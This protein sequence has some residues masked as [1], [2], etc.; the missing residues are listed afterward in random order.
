MMKPSPSHLLRD[1]TAKHGAALILI[2][3]CLVI[4]AVLLLAFLTRAK[5][6]LV[7]SKMYA[8]NNDVHTLMNTAVNIVM[9]QIRQATTTTATDCWTSQPGLIRTFTNAGLPDISYKLYSS[10]TMQV[11]GALNPA[12]EATALA[13]W[14]TQPAAY[15][16]LNDPV[17]GVYPIVDPTLAN[18]S[19][20]SSPQ[21]F[22][23]TAA[24]TTSTQTAPMPVKWLY[25]LQN[26]NLVAPVASG[27]GPTATIAGAGSSPIVGRIAFWTDDETCKVNINTAS[28]GGS[29]NGAT[30]TTTGT[31]TVSWDVPRFTNVTDQNL[32]IYQPVE[33]EFQNYPGHP[34]G[35]SLS[36]VFPTMFVSGPANAAFNPFYAIA[37][38]IQ[39][40]G[41]LN[42]TFDTSAAA[43]PPVVTLDAD[44]LYNSVD[45]LLFNANPVVTNNPPRGGNPVSPLTPLTQ[46]QLEQTKFF[47][48]A[49]SQAPETTIFGTPKIACWPI[50]S[51]LATAPST[52]FASAFDRLIAFCSTA[53]G[54]P[55]YFQRQN[56]EDQNYDYSSIPRNQTLYSYLQ[57]LLGTK[58]PGFGGNLAT[59]FG[60]DTNQILTEIFDYIRCTNLNDQN[61]PTADQYA[62][63][64]TTHLYGQAEV[65]PITIGS[66]RGF[67]RYL[68]INEAALWLI[69]T[70]DPYDSVTGTGHPFADGLY[71]TNNTINLTLSSVLPAT[72]TTISGSTKTTPKQIRIEAALILDPFTPMQGAA[73]MHPDVEVLVS[74]LENWTIKGTNDATPIPLQF[75]S[76]TLQTYTQD[77][78]FQ[79]GFPPDQL[80][81]MFN[82]G[83]YMGAT[84]GLSCRG[85]RARNGGRLPI[86]AVTTNNFVSGAKAAASPVQN[87]Q[88]PFVSE[89]TTVSVVETQTGTT[90]TTYTPLTFSGGPIVVTVRQRSTGT[91]IQTLTLNFP[92]TSVPAPT[93]NVALM[94]SS[95]PV[96]PWTFQAGGCGSVNGFPTTSR[97]NYSSNGTATG[98]PNA[99]KTYDVIY[100]MV[101]AQS[102]QTMDPRFIAMT[103]TLGSGS[104]TDSTGALFSPHP[105][106]TAGT[107]AIANSLIGNPSTGMGAFFGSNSGTLANLG[108]NSYSNGF[109]PVPK[110]PY[111]ATVAMAN[112]DWDTGIGIMA[113][114]G[115]LNE[116]DQGSVKYDS[117]GTAP[118]FNDGDSVTGTLIN[119]TSPNRVMPS[120]GMFGSLPTTFA[121][122]Q[123]A[124]FSG[125]N[126]QGWQT[127][128]FRRQPT[129]PSYVDSSGTTPK[130]SG[131][132]SNAPDYLMMDLF[133]MPVV[134][135]YAI[136]Q[137]LSTAGK[138]N[139]NYQ[140]VPFT[141][142]ERQTGLYALLKHESVTAVPASDANGVY[143]VVGSFNANANYR[144]PIQIGPTLS[145][146]DYRF[147]NS[148]G[149]G[150]Y[151]FR[152]PAEICDVNL[153]PN[154]PNYFLT[155][156]S[157]DT[158]IDTMM[159]AYWTSRA[160]TGD[161]C[162]ERPYTTIYPRL[163][164]RSNTFTV[165]YRVQALKKLPGST[166]TI[167]TEGSDLVQSE[168]RGSMLIERYLDAK[169]TS[170][171]DYAANPTTTPTLDSHYQFRIVSTNR[172]PP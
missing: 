115:F 61:L 3:G 114:G 51:A 71:H 137:M 122:S 9:A 18:G 160:L 53:N 128:L 72:T 125:A 129:H 47:L 79:L 62:G 102:G 36:A 19:S 133:W 155:S 148:D 153:I 11:S 14:S 172:F 161:N 143:K 90:S 113:D 169:D 159:S 162:R 170:I 149:T 107:S 22:T 41:S 27:S 126:N 38:R 23:I 120:P 84:W 16:D 55:Y 138:I 75:P 50:N 144:L 140:I 89:P 105:K 15:T 4:L 82:Y 37:P 100:S 158:A 59:K 171:P 1:R 66:T 134:E 77:G 35:V 80:G 106:Y 12:T 96:E 49:H 87:E 67:G 42:G 78:V 116:P 110:V 33:N 145:Q 70:A 26:G 111:P 24:P 117:S 13:T 10:D 69:C 119:F 30:T 21:G 48:T 108:G 98:N 74:G 123:A 91:V 6:E 135:P 76:Q 34:A 8:D 93:L 52:P 146:F 164:T 94:A 68:T 103:G 39:N 45:E 118:Y 99:N 5:T 43:T 168:G 85:V 86:D 132:F 97:L 63:G 165:H 166:A 65:A 32:A 136:S 157:S 109:Q 40:G 163:T 29:F 92:A 150:L 54:N 112:G 17:S 88:Y 25:V 152:T 60:A 101:G 46:T 20:A 127:L 64:T 44:R 151:A 167:W 57:T 130:G 81:G 104:G 2:L 56:S 156:T 131:G 139:M 28:E 73:P 124:N 7:S 31:N 147:N 121:R 95:P 141:Y 154:D 58:V 83:G 142:I